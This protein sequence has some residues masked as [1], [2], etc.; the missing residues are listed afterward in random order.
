MTPREP[1]LQEAERNRCA[2]GRAAW[3]PREPR[4]AMD[5]PSRQAPGARM[6]RGTHGEAGAG[7]RGKPFGSF[8]RLRK[9]LAR[10]GETGTCWQLGNELGTEATSPT[11]G[12]PRR[13]VYN[14]RLFLRLDSPMTT[15]LALDTAT[16]ACSV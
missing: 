1:P 5:G 16:E 10:G 15:L 8:R 12:N 7:C 3:M 11:S 14:A 6:E 2:G 9:G 13:T 4:R